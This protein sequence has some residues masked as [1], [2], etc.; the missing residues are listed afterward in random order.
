MTGDMT[1]H[2]TGH[3]TGHTTGHVSQVMPVVIDVGT[4]NKALL[5]D[6]DYIGVQA[7]YTYA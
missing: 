2:T 3:M 4:N 7:K 1:G 6:D 5:E